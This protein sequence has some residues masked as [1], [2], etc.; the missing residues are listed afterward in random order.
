MADPEN[1]TKKFLPLDYYYQE[2]N[3]GNDLIKK[4]QEKDGQIIFISFKM[5]TIQKY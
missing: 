1:G 4:Y 5:K 3:L 2:E